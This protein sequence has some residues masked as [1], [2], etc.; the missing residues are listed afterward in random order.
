MRRALVSLLVLWLA[1]IGVT[2]HAAQT[3]PSGRNTAQGTPRYSFVQ[4]SD[5]QLGMFTADRD[6]AQET[7]NFG[8]AIAN[9]N[10]WKPAFVVI[11]GDLINKT[12][13]PA[14]LKE[15]ARLRATIA[16][17]I[18]VYEMPGNHDVENAPTPATVAAYRAAHGP[19]HYAFTYQNLVGIVLDST[20]IHTP[21]KAAAEAAS[22]RAWLDAELARAR[23][24]GASHIVIFQHH[25][26]FLENADEP[27][28]YF[29][30]PLVRRTPLLREFLDSGVTMLVSGHYHRSAVARDGSIE[31]VTTGPVGMPLGGARSGLRIF[32]VN[33]AELTH[34]Y[35]E[36]G[37]L[38]T[39]L[40]PQKGFVR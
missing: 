21:D 32:L 16:K 31:A 26:W 2:P 30:I 27:D 11:T 19:D 36:F 18:P 25:P 34:R 17:D 8:F 3:A 38:P 5:P 10:R 33:G 23:R 37:E 4:L 22:Q 24:S 7:A 14:Q 9:I 39:T 15:Y 35:F 28:Q 29:N 13:D 1:S 12:G 40:D 6:F 20:L